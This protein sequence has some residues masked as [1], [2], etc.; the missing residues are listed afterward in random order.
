MEN[1]SEVKGKKKTKAQN[2]NLHPKT[3]FNVV[4]Y[5][6]FFLKAYIYIQFKICKHIFIGLLLRI[7]CIHSKP[8]DH[9]TPWNKITL[10]VIDHLLKH[11]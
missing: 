1:F 4:I 10:M 3:P 9:R 6:Q 8:Y 7:K 2:Q 11:D 5:I